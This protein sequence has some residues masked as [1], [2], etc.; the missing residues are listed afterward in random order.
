M[1]T[2]TYLLTGAALA[3]S[4]GAS[5]AQTTVCMFKTWDARYPGSVVICDRFA[6][7][8]TAAS[9]GAIRIE[10]FGPETIPPLQQLEPVQNGIFEVLCTYPGFHTGATTLLTGIEAIRPDV[11][12]FR[13]S[14]AREIIDEVYAGLGLRVISVPL[15]H[16]YAAFL[17]QPLSANGDLAGMQIRALPPQHP[18]LAALNATPVVLSPA[19]MF[20]AL[21]RGVVDG[22]LFPMAGAT[23]YGF[24]D[25]TSRYFEVPGTAPHVI[26][27]HPAFWD[28]LSEELRAAF[29][30]QA[31]LLENETPG[32]YTRL[33]AEETAL[34]AARGMEHVKLAPGPEAALR[35][36]VVKGAWSFAATRNPDAAERLRERVEAAG[37]LL[38]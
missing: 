10:M 3:L 14:G 38:Q 25:V 34:M 24:A 6:E 9:A 5:A 28:S 23:G 20:S 8:V 4:V 19:D 33:L 35:E 21:E 1:K 27:A 11:E 22:A 2:L 7:M 26:L 12:G 16:G 30:E 18:Y 37:L 17:R 32:T 36:A 13:A 15:G 29:V 31:I